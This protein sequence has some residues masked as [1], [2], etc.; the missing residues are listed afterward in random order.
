MY[1]DRKAF[2]SLSFSSLAILLLALLLPG[3][4]S[5][6]IL[7]AILLLPLAV[8]VHFAIK[9]RSILSMHTQQVLLLMS[10]IGAL[11]VMLYYVSGIYFGLYSSGYRINLDHILQFVL[12]ISSII[13]TTEWIRRVIR[14]QNSHLADVLI[15][16]CCVCAEALIFSRISSIHTFHQFMDM[17]GLTVLPA[18]VSNLLYHYL[19]K[20]YGALPNIAYRLITTV[21][22]YLIP[23]KSGIS[24]SLLAFTG[25]FLPLLIY[26]FIDV[27]FEKK[28]HYALARKTKLGVVLSV[29]AAA[30]MLGTVMLI[31]NQFRFGALVIA[32]ESM[33]GELN[34]GDAAIFERYDQQD[35]QV[36]QVIVFEN[37]DSMVVHRVIDIKTIN[38]ITRYYTQGDANEAPDTGFITDNQVV[39]LVQWKLPYIG[40]PTLWLRSLFS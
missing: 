17:V 31:S 5:G 33:T 9:K 15:Y 19:S 14:A 10:V 38:A 35:L 25:L 30:I 40:Y 3:Q 2:Y 37:N 1:T 12:P 23:Y 8:V 16:L 27:L 24:D 6:R 7:A 20:R 32:T 28:R 13:I 22:P 39:G 26:I 34:K 11:Y 36:G 18:V 21:I 4:V 29:V